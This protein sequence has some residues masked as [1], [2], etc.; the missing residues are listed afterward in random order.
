M[1]QYG[2]RYVTGREGLI[3]SLQSATRWRSRCS[4]FVFDELSRHPVVST[5]S[6]AV[7]HDLTITVGQG[8]LRHTKKRC[9]VYSKF[10]NE[11]STCTDR[12]PPPITPP[13]QKKTKLYNILSE[14]TRPENIDIFWTSNQEAQFGGVWV[15]NKH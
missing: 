6:S 13:P 14:Q 8:A 4:G 5:R 9:G 7:A 11:Y 1:E 10:R 2:L 12:P 15:Y 3:V